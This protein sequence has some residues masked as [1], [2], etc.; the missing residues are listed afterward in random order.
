M[1]IEIERV[2]TYDIKYLRLGPRPLVLL[3]FFHN[4]SVLPDMYLRLRWTHWRPL[5]IW[6]FYKPNCLNTVF[7]DLGEGESH[8]VG[9]VRSAVGS[10]QFPFHYSGQFCAGLATA[11][12]P[13]LSENWEVQFP[14]FLTVPGPFGFLGLCQQPADA[15]VNLALIH[16]ILQSTNSSSLPKHTLF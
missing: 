10:S 6:C 12:V 8:F 3:P 7:S 2:T 5:N 9:E 11:R 1:V 14:H 4:F 13:F 16:H 15:L